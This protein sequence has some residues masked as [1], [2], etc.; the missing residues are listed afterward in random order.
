[1]IN[2][3]LFTPEMRDELIQRAIKS[4]TKGHT[5]GYFYTLF[6][7]KSGMLTNDNTERCLQVSLTETLAETIYKTD[8]RYRKLSL[9]F[10]GLLTDKIRSHKHL[11]RY[12]DEIVILVKG[13]NGYAYLLDEK[14]NMF[15]FSD[16]DI[17]IYINPFLDSKLFNHIKGIIGTLVLQTISQFKRTLDHILFLD[18]PF[19]EEFMSK[20][21]VSKFKDDFKDMVAER[22]EGKILT[23]FESEEVRNE[24]S[25]HSF[26]ICHSEAKQDTLV[27]VEIPH[28]INCERIP[29]RKTPLFASYN[30]TISFNRTDEKNEDLIDGEFELIRLRI[31]CFDKE[32]NERIPLDFIDVSIPSFRDR[33]LVHFWKHGD[34]V[35]K[36]DVHMNMWVN[37]IDI[38]SALYDLNNMLTIYNCPDWKRKKREEKY[39]KMLEIAG[40]F[41][42]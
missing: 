35:V 24:C 29:L 11:S 31:N 9:H 41:F 22:T 5:N 14:Y 2:K 28:F 26:M 19:G 37:V 16:L 38:N 7:R 33:E 15:G 39:T 1:M 21:L 34:C 40:S 13:S 17:V 12:H 32:N 42:K 10:Y 27:R 3:D 36:K 4:E 25:R 20:E 30:N 6:P 23:P 8:V 18:R